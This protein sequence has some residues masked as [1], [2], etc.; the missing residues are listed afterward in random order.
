MKASNPASSNAPSRRS[1]S[2]RFFPPGYLPAS[3]LPV[4]TQYDS[5]IGFVRLA[6]RVDQT[7]EIEYAGIGRVRGH[8]SE[9]C[10]EN[11]FAATEIRAFPGRQHLLHLAPLCVLVRAAQLAGNDA[12]LPGPRIPLDL[13]LGDVGQRADDDVTAVLGT[14]FRRHGLEAPA[15]K[16]VEE[17]RL[18]DV[19][20]M[21][22]Q[23]DLR[24]A[25]L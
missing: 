9:H 16:Q 15:K 18:H 6:I 20:A 12:E 2:C 3:S 23:R 1:S 19:V 5:A 11:R 7:L 10:R 13:R 8:D 21:M 25:V 17:Q 14:Q 4:M 24:D 22:A